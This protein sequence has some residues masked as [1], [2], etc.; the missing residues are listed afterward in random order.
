MF[1]QGQDALL[2]VWREALEHEHLGHAGPADAFAPGDV[3]LP[4]DCAGFEFPLPFDGLAEGFGHER[5]TKRL[6]RHGASDAVDDGFEWQLAR[7]A[8]DVPVLEGPNWPEGDLDGLL[9]V[10]AGLHGKR[11]KGRTGLLRGVYGHVGDAEPDLRDG[12]SGLTE[13]SSGSRIGLELES[14]WL[15]APSQIKSSHTDVTSEQV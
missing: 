11:H 13:G 6:G 1:D 14:V 2:D 8:A 10:L 12:P 4:G 15:T 3:G 5:Y 9:S 7:E